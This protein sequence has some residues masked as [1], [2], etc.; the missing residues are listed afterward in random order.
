MT[1]IYFII[2]QYLCL[3]YTFPL[4]LFVCYTGE[5]NCPKEFILLPIVP[6]ELPKLA[7]DH[8]MM[9]DLNQLKYAGSHINLEDGSIGMNGIGGTG[10]IGGGGGVGGSERGNSHLRSSSHKNNHRNNVLN[11]NHYLFNSKHPSRHS[12]ISTI[13]SSL[14]HLKPRSA[15]YTDNI[16]RNNSIFIQP[17]VGLDTLGG[18]LILFI[19]IFC[20]FP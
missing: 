5:L 14:L 8:K 3:L 2:K 4:D 13:S 18:N 17:L 7:Y 16:Y 1:G 19:I 12:F 6:H 9:T 20:F 10:G 11:K 15:H